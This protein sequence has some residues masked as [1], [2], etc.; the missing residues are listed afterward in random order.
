MV[1]S[2]NHR[3]DANDGIFLRRQDMTMFGRGLPGL[4]CDCALVTDCVHPR[5]PLDVYIT[6]S[7]W[8]WVHR[9]TIVLKL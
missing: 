8:R 4:L 7:G 1:V 6:Y 2:L 5:P 3:T 9:M